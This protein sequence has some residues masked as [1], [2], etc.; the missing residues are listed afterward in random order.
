MLSWKDDSRYA[1]FVAGH[2]YGHPK[3]KDDLIHPP[4]TEKRY[5]IQQDPDMRMGFF[6]GD[7]VRRAKVA[8]WDNVDRFLATLPVP[9]YFAPG[10]HDMAKRELFESRYGKTFFSFVH[11]KDL[12]I[13]LD[14]NLDHWNISGEQLAFLKSALEKHESRDRVFVL[15]HQILW[16][17]RKP[18]FRQ[19]VPN[20]PMG[21]A[22]TINFFT[23]LEPLFLA[24]DKPV[25]LIAGDAGVF[26]NGLSVMYHEYKNIHYIASGMGGG[27]RDNYLVFKVRWDGSV[28]IQVMALNGDDL[29]ALGRARDNQVPR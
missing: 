2:V 28:D 13:V 19:F 18:Y 27:S 14:P 7:I 1:F 22:E 5:L 20:S 29:H 15:F 3:D 25:Y 8:D 12:F 4:F 10:N 21:R 11:D 26:P 9:V 16:W 6:T 23:E 17:D 24:L